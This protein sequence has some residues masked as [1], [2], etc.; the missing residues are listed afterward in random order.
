MTLHT[1]R[2]RIRRTELIAL[3]DGGVSS[4]RTIV[5]G[6]LTALA[7]PHVAPKEA[8]PPTICGEILPERLSTA[9]VTAPTTKP[10]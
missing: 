9:D 4:W 10:A 7:S 5:R 6:A 2:S 3:T 1:Q 8:Q